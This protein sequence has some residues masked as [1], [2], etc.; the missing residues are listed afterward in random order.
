MSKNADRRGN[1]KF[2]G[3]RIATTHN[4]KTAP[5]NFLL[6]QL[7]ITP[8]PRIIDFLFGLRVVLQF[9]RGRTEKKPDTESADES[10]F[11]GRQH[12]T[13]RK[14]KEG[15][16]IVSLSLYYNVDPCLENMALNASEN[17]REGE[18]I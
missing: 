13:L 8:R 14:A 9:P 11:N 15:E 16:T 4:G 17:E 10:N 2:S 12:H 5:F 6:K 3:C 7:D 18:P 1:A